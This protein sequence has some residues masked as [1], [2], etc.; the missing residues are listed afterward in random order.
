MDF[1]LSSSVILVIAVALWLLWVAPYVLR[2][3]RENAQLALQSAGEGNFAHEAHTVSNLAPGTLHQAPVQQQENSMN[4]TVTATGSQLNSGTE[5]SEPAAATSPEFHV[6]WGRTSLA[7]AGLLFL[8]AGVVM[9]ILRIFD[10]GVTWLPGVLFLGTAASVVT[11]RRLAIADRRAKVDAAFREAMNP[12]SGNVVASAPLLVKTANPVFD[13]DATAAAA[14]ASDVEAKQSER[15]AM[16][17]VELRKAAL[18]VAEASGDL[19]LQTPVAEREWA[20][21]EVPKPAYVGAAKAERPAP[22]PL[23]LPAEPKPVGRPKLKDGAV[24]PDINGGLVATASPAG[25]YVASKTGS[26]LGNL[27]DVLQRRRA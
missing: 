14:K 22:E 12:S 10:I 20:P 16:T 15:K 5:Q 9:G 3:R 21:V 1:P 23:D 13:A 27:D 2:V 18:A 17:A 8:F 26:A 4:S 19:P 11:L 24:A 6:R 7:V 25:K